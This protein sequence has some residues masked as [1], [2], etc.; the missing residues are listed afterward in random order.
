M[1]DILVAYFSATGTT[2]KVAKKLANSIGGDLFE[3]VPEIPYTKEDLVWT[4]DTSR[5][6]ME[7]TDITCRPAIE[8]YLN[9]MEHYDKVFIGFPIWWYREPAIIDT[10]LEQYD[11]TGKTIIPFATSKGSG[12]GD[13][14]KNIQELCPGAT[15]VEGKR[16]GG[17]TF[18]GA[19]VNWANQW[20]KK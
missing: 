7:M 14:S 11:F 15:V 16:F 18:V 13:C 5:S 20:I 1:S 6:S 2:E 3:I 19:L 9:Y 10:F 4:D 12:M 8:S 17:I